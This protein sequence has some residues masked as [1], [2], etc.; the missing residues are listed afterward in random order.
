MCPTP[1]RSL[2][3][4]ISRCPRGCVRLAFGP[5]VVHLSAAEFEAFAALVEAARGVDP[6]RAPA[7]LPVPRGRA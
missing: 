4:A 7:G 5:A 6:P 3:L 1:R 2:D